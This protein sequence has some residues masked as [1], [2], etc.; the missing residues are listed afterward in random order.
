M[1]D[2]KIIEQLAHLLPGKRLL[3]A[4]AHCR[5]KGSLGIRKASGFVQSDA[6]VSFAAQLASK[7]PQT[8]SILL[9]HGPI[10]MWRLCPLINKLGAFGSKF[11]D[12]QLM[13]GWR[14]FAFRRKKL[15]L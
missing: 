11:E 10:L 13:P 9:F 6:V 1:H 12:F 14:L 7:N 3:P 15:F 8:L 2:S 5:L 4:V